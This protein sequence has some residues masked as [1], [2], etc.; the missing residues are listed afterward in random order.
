MAG[1]LKSGT[2]SLIDRERVRAIQTK[3]W[4]VS[5]KDDPTG[6]L[7]GQRG[8]IRQ[9]NGFLQEGEIGEPAYGVSCKLQ[10]DLSPRMG[11]QGR[12]PSALAYMLM[13]VGF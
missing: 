12:A 4:K 10:Q 5:A 7:R 11:G 13:G 8:H 1:A 6:R 3:M 9:I 2:T